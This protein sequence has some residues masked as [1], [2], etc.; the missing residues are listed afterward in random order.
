MLVLLFRWGCCVVL[1][2]IAPLK[3]GSWQCAVQL[4]HR[5]QPLWVFL[6]VH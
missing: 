5:M 4:L 1:I 3:V 6:A 2:P